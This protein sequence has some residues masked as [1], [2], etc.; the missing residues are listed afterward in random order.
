[1]QAVYRYL[2]VFIGVFVSLPVAPI[3]HG[4]DAPYV[5]TPQNVIDAMLKISAVSAQDYLVDLGSGDGRIVITAAKQLGARGMGVEL[6]QNLVRT[7][8]RDAQREGVQDRVSFVSDDLFFADLSKATVI[9]VYMSEAV[10]LRLRLLLFEL[11]PGTRVVSHDFDMGNWKPDSKLT[12]PVP[13]K[14]YGPPSSDILLWVVPADFSGTWSWRQAVNGLEG[15]HEAVFTQKFQNAEGKGQIAERQAAIGKLEIKGDAISFVMGAEVAGKATW[16]AFQG[17]IQ[18]DIISGTAVTIVEADGTAQHG[19]SV[20]W[21]A[22]RI[23]RGGMD[24]EPAVQPFGS[25]FFTK[26]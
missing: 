14:R 17:R 22:T 7:A 11:K 25:G 19:V 16:K 10:N 1:M 6:D 12:V 4:A 23:K 8:T 13:G 15:A 18:G 24:I 9:T 3:V 2:I 5:T 20:P 26:E 21:R